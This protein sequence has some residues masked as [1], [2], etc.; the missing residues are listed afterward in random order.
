MER[1]KRLFLVILVFG[2]KSESLPRFSLPYTLREFSTV[3]L[4]YCRPFSSRLA[5]QAPSKALSL[6][7]YIFI[8]LA[9]ALIQ[10]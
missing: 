2:H 1:E 4:L 3:L 5:L 8:N 7:L 9:D 10:Q 6:A